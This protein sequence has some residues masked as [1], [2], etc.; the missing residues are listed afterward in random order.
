MKVSFSLPLLLFASSSLFAQAFL[1]ASPSL[2]SLSFS[3]IQT[4]T[5]QRTRVNSVSM[6]DEATIGGIL[7]GMSGLG[8]GIGAMVFTEGQQERRRERQ[9]KK[10]TDMFTN[11]ND[12]NNANEIGSATI[13]EDTPGSIPTNS[14]SNQ[15]NS[16]GEKREMEEVNDDG[17]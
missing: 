16:A 2:S 1:P 10:R 8:L 4:T 17:W 14:N 5:P 11:N 15:S 6:L 13:T 7:A 3:P 9:A 12:N